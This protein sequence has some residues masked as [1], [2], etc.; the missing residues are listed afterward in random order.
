MPA[1]RCPETEMD[2]LIALLAEQQS[3]PAGP[4]HRLLAEVTSAAMRDPDTEHLLRT[5]LDR[6]RSAA[7]AALSNDVLAGVVVDLYLGAI[8]SKSLNRRQPSEEDMLPVL[9]RLIASDPT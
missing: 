1:S 9:R 2:D 4:E 7:S 3:T 5:C 6:L 8:T